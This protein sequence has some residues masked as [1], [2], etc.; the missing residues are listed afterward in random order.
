MFK[1]TT[2]PAVKSSQSIAFEGRPASDSPKSSRSSGLSRLFVGASISSIAFASL[3]ATPV[4]AQVVIVDDTPVQNP[5]GQTVTSAAGVTQTVNNGDNIELENDTNDNTV[6]TLAGTHINNDGDDEDVVIFVDNSEDNVTIN[7][8]STGVLQGV[9]G[10]IFYEGDGATIINDGIIEGTGEADEAV[11]YFDRDADGLVNS[12]TNNGTITSVGGATIGVDTL[13]GTDP[14]SGTVGDEEGIARFTLLNTGTISNTGTDSDADA[15][16][17]NGD[18]GNTSG[19]DRGCLEGALVLCRVEVDITNSGTISA[20]RDSS[21]NAAI[22]VEQDAVIS[23]TILNQ[24]GGMIVGGSNA[25]TIDGAHADHDLLITNAGTITGTSSSGIWIAGSGVTVNNQAGGVITGGDEGIL[26]EGTT[27]TVDNGATNTENVAVT[28]DNINVTNAGTISGGDTG[29]A[30]GENAAGFNLLNNGVVTGDVGISSVSGGN[31]VTNGTVTGTGGTA[32]ALSGTENAQVGLGAGAVINGDVI[33]TG[34]GANLFS[35]FT[36]GEITGEISGSAN[37]TNNTFAV[38]ASTGSSTVTATGFNTLGMFGTDGTI[39]FTS[40]SSGF[41][42]GISQNGGT[43]IFNGAA[44]GDALVFGGGVLGG[45]GSIAG[46]VSLTEAS[47][48]S[49]GEG[50]VGTLMFGSLNLAADSILQFDLGAPDTVG[51]SDL[52]IVN[53]DL[54]LDGTLI[55][56]DVGGFGIGVYRLIDYSGALTDNGLEVGTLP[57][58]FT[59]DQAEVQ[60]SVGTQVN[61]VISNATGPTPDVQFWDGADIAADAAIDGGAGSWDITTPNWTNAAGDANAAWNNN[62]AVFAG[63]AGTVTVDGA[64]SFTGLQFMTDGY[65]LAQGAGALSITDPATNVRVDSGVTATIAAAITGTGGINQLDSGTLVLSGVNTY[66]GNTAIGGTLVLDG[67]IAG[68]ASVASGGTLSGT[69]TAVGAVTLTNGATLA[70]GGNGSAG[71]LTT[72]DLILASGSILSYDLGAPGSL[73]SSDRVQVNGDL[74]LDGLLNT[75]DIG[76]FGVGVYRLI[77]YTGGLTD[78]GLDVGVLPSGF[79]SSAGTVQTSV[80]GQVNLIVAANIPDIQF[81]DGAGTTA[82]GAIGGGSGSWNLT[83]TNWTNG[84]GDANAAWNSNF[85]VFTGAAGTVTVDDAISLTGLQFMTNGYAISAGSGALSISEAAT[86]VRVDPGVTATI[87]APIGGAGGINQL[88]SGTLILNGNHTYTGATVVDGGRLVVNGSLVS[89]VTVNSGAQ[90]GGSGQVGSLAVIGTV[91][92]GNSIGTLNVAGNLSFAATSQY[93]V[94][95]L[96]DGTS[97]LIAAGGAATINGGTVNVLAGGTLYNISTDYTILTAGGGVTGTFNSVN[98]NLAFLTPTLSYED[99]SVLLNLARN[100]VAFAAVGQTANQKA[101]GAALQS[102]GNSVLGNQIVNLDAVSAQDAF[103]QLSGEVH[104][105]VRTVMTE[106]NRLVR[107]AVLDHLTENEGGSIWGDFWGSRGDSDGDS[108]AAGLSRDGFGLLFGADVAIG[109]GSSLGLAGGYTQTDIDLDERSGS[110]S[111]NLGSGT[112]ETFNVVAYLGV[113]L[114]ALN[115]RT[116]GGYGWVDV[117]TNRSVAFNSFADTLTANYAGSTLFGF[118]ELG[119]RVDMG[120]GYV[121]PYAGVS[122]IEAE[123]PGFAESGGDAALLVTEAIENSLIS[124]LGVR[125]GTSEE[126]SFRLRGKAGWQHGFGDLTPT[127]SVRF[128]TGSAFEIAGGPQSRN[129]GYIQAEALYKISENGSIGVSYD[130]V[131]GN[132]SQDHAVMGRITIGF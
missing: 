24:T 116:G 42:S 13:L 129:A 89:A 26:I 98:S 123:T 87:S 33:F 109:E 72:G 132:A 81:W 101:A 88:D 103:D 83:N 16:N 51:A 54:T 40:A 14:S 55:A 108:N 76:G 118:A 63:A 53:G 7:I 44:T 90:L 106:D 70:P 68:T 2:A 97:D 122:F 28:A 25:I 117:S 52:L 20:D 8:A 10:V 82:N 56:N 22:R 84:S 50:G 125:F 18:P 71:T 95:V 127:S 93:N 62:F 57:A 128:D 47:T 27:I 69:G 23:G 110:G 29:I 104:P 59:N 100:D 45:T 39:V 61:L 34:S 112:V 96:P 119:H 85:A 31:I 15:I 124:T 114:G 1:I 60:T 120:S 9:N 30:V 6:I 46:A 102:Q 80:G 130:G 3:F 38:T 65:T 92:P 35:M 94:E 5:G 37:S 74:T 17:F 115:F 105:T 113:E 11:V 58:G 4:H 91:A 131:Y 75:S 41:G 66:T 99:N 43:L 36:N 121:E 79:D 107:N 78:N 126:A 86:A 48:I 32:I 111:A 21:S 64:I 12:L 77:D 73:A 67:T 49:A 19:S